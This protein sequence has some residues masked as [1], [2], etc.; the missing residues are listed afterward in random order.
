MYFMLVIA[1]WNGNSHYF[2]MQ[3]IPNIKS[4]VLKIWSWRATALQ[5]LVP[6]VI[7]HT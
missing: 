7:K 1:N 2:A 5:S 3:Y 4:W 6:V